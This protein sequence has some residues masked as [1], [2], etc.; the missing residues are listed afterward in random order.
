[1]TT[2][3]CDLRFFITDSLNVCVHRDF[4]VCM[5]QQFLNN[6]RVLAVRVQDSAERVT[7]G[8]PTDTLF[9]KPR[10]EVASY[11]PS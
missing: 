8:K 9:L 10:V 3:L 11:K 1:L 7:K 2:L 6:F 5:A 4:E